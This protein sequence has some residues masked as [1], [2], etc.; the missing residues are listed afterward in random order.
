M[1]SLKEALSESEQLEFYRNCKSKFDEAF[2]KSIAI[3]RYYQIAGTAVCLKFA[4]D[5]LVKDLTSALAHLEIEKPDVVHFTI[6]AWD[7]KS[8]GVKM[9]PPPCNWSEFTDRGDVWGFGNDRIKIAFHWSEFSLNLMDCQNN[10]AI[11][12]V[13]KADAFPYWV[14]SSPFRSIINW[15][16]E[17]NDGQL[18]HAAA[19][20]NAD[21]AI[22]ITGKGG[23]G[24][25]STALKGLE[26]GMLYLADDYLIVK[27]KPQPTVFSL[28][29]S[30][31]LVRQDLEKYPLFESHLS[32]FIEEE[33]EKGVFFLY[34]ELKDK[35]VISL[36]IK[37]L[38][39]PEI[40]GLIESDFRS[41][42]K[43]DMSKALAFTTMSQLPYSGV[44][45]YDFINALVENVLI[46]KLRLGTEKRQLTELLAKTC[47]NSEPI[48]ELK[49]I[50]EDKLKWPLLTVIIP[51]Y[52]GA[53]FINNALKNVMDQ[54]Y[55]GLEIILVDDGSKDKTAEVVASLKED[56]RCF[57]QPNS[58]PAA[59]RNRGL[60]DASGEFI[61]FLDVDD[62]WPLHTLKN[63]VRRLLEQ[64][65]IDI[66][67]GYGQLYKL[68]VLGEEV[69]I[70]NPK[71]SFKDYIGAAIYRKEVFSKVGLF[72][73]S[74]TF[75]EDSDW[76]NRARELKLN[77][78]REQEVTLMVQRHGANMTEGKN[79]VELSNLKL[80]K[81][82]LD[83]ERQR[84]EAG[85]V[86]ANN[87]LIATKIKKRPL[88]SIL[89]QAA[90]TAE[91][92][93]Q[94][95]EKILS[96]EYV[97]LEIILYG[98]K[99]QLDSVSVDCDLVK[100]EGLE[101]SDELIN[102]SNGSYLY[103]QDENTSLTNGALKQLADLLV[104]KPNFKFVMGCTIVRKMNGPQVVLNKSLCLFRKSVFTHL[105][106][107][108]IELKSAAWLDWFYRYREV[109]EMLPIYKHVI[110]FQ[111]G[112]V[113]MDEND[114]SDAQDL[115][116][117]RR[118]NSGLK[119]L[120]PFPE[121]EIG[122]DFVDFWSHPDD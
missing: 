23:V 35:I 118:Q 45:T 101:I 17:L 81:K 106:G 68:S 75:G 111:F 2:N 80:F 20:G 32:N 50:D 22:V 57:Y 109:G 34:P 79:L 14:A 56:V 16:M 44:Y 4:G 72:D 71:E 102:L 54:Q 92:T 8:T 21:G 15:W 95:I 42:S 88:L 122:Q 83:R 37:A 5:T 77:I 120:Y 48:K 19:I 38:L 53:K 3:K 70:G 47:V 110:A 85:Y 90:E 78:K 103:F 6:N 93:Q 29:S 73:E 100:F 121:N 94:Q 13:Q 24:K 99:L 114:R 64:P 76:F 59:A 40:T 97:P 18:L 116:I 66:L 55:P 7:S 46:A 41:I 104:A 67:R 119:K 52:N 74:M 117:K 84:Q 11:Y 61:A 9:L 98:T 49:E 69:F 89:M 107:L 60:R 105:G 87:N 1:R 96:Q 82:S 62:Y 33:Q 10:E 65:D 58:G 51:T 30:A 115:S 25:S 36:P 108:N 112:Q 113:V 31:K 28:Y 86:V 91:I 39:T 63:L 43:T 12:W 26:A 27:N